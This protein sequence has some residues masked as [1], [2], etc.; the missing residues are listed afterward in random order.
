MTTMMMIII[1]INW[2]LEWQTTRDFSSKYSDS[3]ATK[4]VKCTGFI[5]A[6]DIWVWRSYHALRFWGLD[7]AVDYIQTF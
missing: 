3:C 5:S 4:H 7:C 1:I 6:K 2:Y